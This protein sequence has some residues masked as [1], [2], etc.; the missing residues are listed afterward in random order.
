MEERPRTSACRKGR[1]LAHAGANVQAERR[2]LGPWHAG[3]V[4]TRRPAAQGDT[5]AAKLFALQL[6]A[7]LLTCLHGSSR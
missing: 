1:F 7:M 5:L 6:K 4:V 2:R 3:A